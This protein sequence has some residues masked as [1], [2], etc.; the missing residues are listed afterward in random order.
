MPNRKRKH[1]ASSTAPGDPN[2]GFLHVQ[3]HEADI[4][5]NSISAKSLESNGPNIGEAL[6]KHSTA[7]NSEI[8]LDRCVRNRIPTL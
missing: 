4:R 5:H 2:D 8:W 6:I 7:D 3:V 1:G